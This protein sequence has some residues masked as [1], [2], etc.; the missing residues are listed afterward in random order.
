MSQKTIQRKEGV[1]MNKL[2][3]VRSL[4]LNAKKVKEEIFK[5]RLEK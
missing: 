2:A 5:R 1:K 3:G 4:V